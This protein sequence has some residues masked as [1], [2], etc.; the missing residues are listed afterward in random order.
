MTD[1]TIT[2]ADRE[3][4]ERAIQQA[5]LINPFLGSNK[6]WLIEA[7]AAHRLSAIEEAAQIAEKHGT[8]TVAK[9]IRALAHPNHK[10]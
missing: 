1:I 2:E 5:P 6:Q 10:G 8:H 9:D 4:A 7:L 3:A